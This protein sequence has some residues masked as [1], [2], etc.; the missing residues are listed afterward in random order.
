M[1]KNNKSKKKEKKHFLN[2]SEKQRAK[3]NKRADN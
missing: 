3:P 2:V 1:E